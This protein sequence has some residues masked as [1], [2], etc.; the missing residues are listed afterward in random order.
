MRWLEEVPPIEDGVEDKV[1]N[2]IFET[3]WSSQRGARR[4]QN[5]RGVFVGANASRWS[6]RRRKEA[7]M[8]E[9]DMMCRHSPVR[10]CAER[11]EEGGG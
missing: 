10:I 6:R 9:G 7:N 1:E 2:K 4:L 3:F 11:I 8:K 5:M